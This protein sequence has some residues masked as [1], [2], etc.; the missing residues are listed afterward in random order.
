MPSLQSV[1]RAASLGAR[2]DATADGQ[3]TR[4]LSRCAR[5][6]T[7]SV[8]P[9]C[10]RAGGVREGHG[11]T[12]DVERG[13]HAPLGVR[14]SRPTG[15]ST[16][17]R[18]PRRVRQGSSANGPYDPQGCVNASNGSIIADDVWIDVPTGVTPARR[19]DVV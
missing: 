17:R 13:Q 5:R 12:D 8:R 14:H 3:G 1:M 6:E 7:R 16:S 4:R 19:L 2:R 9:T 11:R 18:R 15:L 10:H